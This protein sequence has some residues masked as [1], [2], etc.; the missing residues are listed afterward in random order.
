MFERRA[1]SIWS[2]LWPG[3]SCNCNS[4]PPLALAAVMCSIIMPP[5]VE[6]SS[7]LQSLAS[8]KWCHLCHARIARELQTM[9]SIC[10][11][12]EIC[13]TRKKERKK[14]RRSEPVHDGCHR[15]CCKLIVAA[16]PLTLASSEPNQPAALQSLPII[17]SHFKTLSSHQQLQPHP[18]HPVK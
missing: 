5:N 14:T 18:L 6:C 7:L 2:L 17:T 13:S 9:S 10:S 8:H 16:L 11:K 1:I 3:P 12:M 15:P 4:P